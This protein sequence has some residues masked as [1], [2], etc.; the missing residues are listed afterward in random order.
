MASTLMATKAVMGLPA[1]SSRQRLVKS[2]KVGE[3][4]RN[5]AR[6]WNGMRR[7]NC[8]ASLVVRSTT[9]ICNK[10]RKISV[11]KQGRALCAK[12][13]QGGGGDDRPKLTRESEPKT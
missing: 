13:L 12:A 5:R 1:Q 6:S 10:S 9:T 8:T 11:K 3:E 4:R 7:E 2:C